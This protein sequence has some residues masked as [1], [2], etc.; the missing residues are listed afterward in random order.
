MARGL[1]IAAFQ[2][3]DRLRDSVVIHRLDAR[4]TS[5]IYLAFDYGYSGSLR[6]SDH[7]GEI[8]TYN[9]MST[10]RA[11]TP[12]GF[13]SLD[14][15]NQCCSDI[16][17]NR[18]S[19]DP[20]PGWFWKWAICINPE[21]KEDPPMKIKLDPGAFPPVR[22]HSTDAGLDLLTPTTVFLRP[23]ASVTVDTGVH[24]QLPPNT[25]GLL[26]SKSG[27]NVKFGITS[28]G[29]IDEGYTGSIRVKLYNNSD[30]SHTFERGDKLSQL[31]VLPV[32]YPKVKIVHQLDTSE[33][34]DNG[35][36]STGS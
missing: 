21:I 4:S 19:F 1:D 16:L 13:Y 24:I 31:V 11:P 2:I 20:E 10:L 36:G 34:G 6:I 8:H 29:V 35:F 3:I 23:H 26:K 30:F 33:R 27:L 18:Y 28:D 12:N 32:L 25:V 17:S 15:I 9:I 7:V 5:S 22:E 14:D